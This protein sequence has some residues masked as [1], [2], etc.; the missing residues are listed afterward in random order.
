[1]KVITGGRVISMAQDAQ[2]KD[3]VWEHGVVVI[4]DDGKITAVG[5]V[6]KVAVPDG[7]EIV[8]ASGKV[9]TPGFI[10][11]HTHVGI[12]EMATGREGSDTNE[13]SDPVT[14]QVRAIDAIYPLDSAFGDA[15]AAGITAVNVMPGSGNV[16]CG[17]AVLLKT[18][19]TRID[20][21]VVRHPTGLKAAMGENPKKN[22]GDQKKM[23][24]TR[25]GVAGLMRENLVKASNYLAKRDASQLANDP[26][27][28]FERDLKM[29]HLGMVL[30]R[31][32]P[33][34]W[35]A[36][37]S[38]DILTALR[39]RD[40][41]G[42]DMVVDHATEGYLV[43]DELVKRNIP[44]V[45]GP[46]LTAR[47]KVELK[48]RSLATPGIM[49]RAGVKVA[50]T[51]DHYV[52]PVQYLPMSLIM[53]VKEGLER[54]QALRLV[55]INP[56]EIMGVAD[57]IGSLAPGKDADVVVWSG[58]PLDIYQRPERVYVDGQAVYE[59]KPGPSLPA[60]N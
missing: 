12:M 26:A 4:G 53:A 17:L 3:Q 14:P 22:Y 32:I 38:D 13:S 31:E 10:D 46:T 57:R 37:R 8:D 2:G 40:E 33:M 48:G 19:G 49:V 60:L 24:T 23:P 55:T 29:E 51:T 39:I 52:V 9:V 45:V 25:M 34:R 27:K 16:I 30:R 47:Y 54:E 41:F 11:A 18:Y 5:E 58:D 43:A 56:A 44:A 50:L 6:G 59:Y 20:Q 21:M 28:P 42:F 35:H 1:M 7:A 36:H 15:L